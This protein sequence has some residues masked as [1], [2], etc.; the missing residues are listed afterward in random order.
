MNSARGSMWKQQDVSA[1]ETE[2]WGR[3]EWQRLV[4]F[5]QL[6]RSCFLQIMSRSKKKHR[7]TLQNTHTDRE[8]KCMPYYKLKRFFNQQICNDVLSFGCKHESWGRFGIFLNVA[9][10]RAWLH[11]WVEHVYCALLSPFGQG[12]VWWV[13]LPLQFWWLL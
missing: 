10:P 9:Q 13:L 12:S 11:A 4:F 2:R 3:R 6:S 7:A 8:R 1:L 5:I